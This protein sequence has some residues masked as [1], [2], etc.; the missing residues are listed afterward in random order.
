MLLVIKLLGSV[1]VLHADA[2]LKFA[3]DHTR[4][5]LAYLVVESE[6]PHSRS[7]LAAL[8]WPDEREAVARHNLRQALSFLK[9]ALNNVPQRDQILSIT[10]AEVQWTNK[11]VVVDLHEFFHLREWCQKHTHTEIQTCEAC[12]ERVVQAV[13]L[14]RGEFMDSFAIKKSQSFEEWMVVVREQAHRQAM[15]MLGMLAQHFMT[16]GAYVEA[17][18]YASRRVG[19]EPW[20]EDTHRQLMQAYAAQGQT[21]AA[22]RQYERCRDVLAKE[23][24]TT[25]SAETTQLYE[26]VL[27][28]HSASTMAT[29]AGAA[30]NS[31]RSATLADPVAVTK[32]LHNLPTYLPPM[33]GRSQQ[34]QN[35]LNMLAD[36]TH[37]MIT[38]V[39]MGGIGKTRLALGLMAHLVANAPATFPHGIWFVSLTSITVAAGELA[40]TVAEAIGNTLN[41]YAQS[42]ADWQAVVFNHLAQRRIALVLDNAEHLLQPE[43]SANA[44]TD[45]L[46][47]LLQAA[48]SLT[49][50]ITSRVP[51]QL[52][53]EQV[54][55]LEG[56]PIPFQG[57]IGNKDV[58]DV[59]DPDTSVG[60]F[61]QHAQRILPRFQLTNENLPIIVEIC[62]LLGGIPLALELAAALV[63][64]FT[65]DELLAAIRQN[66]AV[67]VSTRRDM[68]ARHRRFAAVLES[69]WQLLSEHEARVLMQCALFSGPF[70]R[71]AAQAVTGATPLDLT[72]LLDKS[73][74]QQGEVGI[75]DLHELLRQFAKQKL[76][77]LEPSAMRALQRRYVE[78][79]LGLV[80][81]SNAALRQRGAQA[82][83]EQL[84][85]AGENCR[86]AWEL[87]LE[88]HWFEPMQAAIEGLERYWE[89]T[90][91]HHDGEKLL[92]PA[93]A[94][95][96]ASRQSGASHHDLRILTRFRLS[97]SLCLLGQDRDEACH[98]ELEKT[99][100]LAQAIGDDTCL[101]LALAFLSAALS[102]QNRH[103]E[104]YLV[105]KRAYEYEVWDAQIQ[106]LITLSN[107]QP[108][109][110]THIATVIQALQIAQQHDDPYLILMCTNHIA[111]SYENEGYFAA[112]LPYRAQGLQLAYEFNAYQIA[113]A[114]YCYGLVHAHLGVYDVA[115]KQFERALLMAQEHGFDGIE[116]RSLNRFARTY[117]LIG[118]LDSAYDYSRQVQAKSRQD[119]EPHHFFYFTYAQI[120]VGLTRWHEAESVLQT[121]L[122][123]K[124][125]VDPAL[126][127][128]LLPELAELARLALWQNNPEQALRYVEDILEIERLHP[129]IYMPELYF[130]IFAVDVACYEVLHML[131]DAR[132]NPMLATSHQR[133]NAQLAQIADPEIRQSYLERVPANRALHQAYLRTFPAD[134]ALTVGDSLP[135]AM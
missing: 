98:V 25:P 102:R 100:V 38:L 4:A 55:R 23:L 133:L 32:R 76:A 46:L 86:R 3:T 127:P 52:M 24:G 75:Y 135:T 97:Y 111:G 113:E 1:Q 18:N 69:S 12:I 26:L 89:L 88:H 122:N 37:R 132:A 33:I 11:D 80:T 36:P 49:L 73:L 90:G 61:G 114:E 29:G 103:S 95:L 10:T 21:S 96:E 82:A 87:A 58:K 92:V 129:R 48:P 134:A 68:D 19:L 74:L 30:A 93:I 51:L 123:R 104:A 6:I 116:R 83:V 79:Y 63:A 53:A 115:L 14:Y 43:A 35:V 126:N 130:D 108:N 84:H 15:E 112:S 2:P 20:Q 109:V 94:A 99:M 78:H 56:L 54:V 28:K 125:K 42:Q 101:A 9:K 77:Q 72:G 107:H 62:A 119:P 8:L 110:Q 118:Q 45:F 16:K 34:L 59:V 65:P 131:G 70:S 60:L 50:L 105:A 71:A 31:A 124:R 106:A 67:L 5:L 81:T 47:A 39:G 27:L 17:Q 128:T 121:L 7:K 66:L 44:L 22:V 91:G 64:H 41:I 85:Q 120:L 13:S 57:G 40:K 117:Y